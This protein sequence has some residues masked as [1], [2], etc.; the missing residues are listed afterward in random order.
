MTAFAVNL[1]SV[2]VGLGL[3]ALGIIPGGAPTLPGFVVMFALTL[4]VETALLRFLVRE[5]APRLATVIAYS[6]YMN[7]ASYA[8]IGLLLLVGVLR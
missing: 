7:V 1:L 8:L 2:L 6:V 4:V 5:H 3:I